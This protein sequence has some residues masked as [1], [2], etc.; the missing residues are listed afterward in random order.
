MLKTAKP[1]SPL[2]SLYLDII[3]FAAATAVLLD[4]LVSYPITG[5][6]SQR[7]GWQLIG[8]YGQTAV[9][10]FFVLSGYVIALVVDTREKDGSSYA[11]SRISRLYSVVIPALVLTW[12]SDWLGQTIDP[13]FYAHPKIFL[14]PPSSEGY[15]ASFF[16]LNEFQVFNFRGLAPG[17]NAPFWSLSFEATYYLV[18]GLALFAP[19]RI[20]IAMSALVL[21][22]AGGTIA[23]LLPLWALGYLSYVFRTEVLQIIR[24]PLLVF[25]ASGILILAI[26]VLMVPITGAT[27]G[28]HLPFGRAELARDVGKD[29][30][31]ALAF[32]VHIAAAKAVFDGRKSEMAMKGRLV[33][34]IRF[35][36]AATFPLYAMHFP[37]LALLAVL[38]PF[39]RSSAPHIV[40]LLSGVLI[41]VAACTPVCDLLRDRMKSVLRRGMANIAATAGDR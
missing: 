6:G 7:A 40:W 37:L 3:R 19:K 10:L 35:A 32:V 33:S 41:V 31:T 23:V 26:P 17:S 9:T 15:L 2:L 8:N 12:L 34:G 36:G 38:S 13:S 1:I 27:M 24:W 11:I 16:F 14:K 21:A 28:I 4:H 20:A 30:A 22:C 25:A 29:Y 39:D 5:D 18:A